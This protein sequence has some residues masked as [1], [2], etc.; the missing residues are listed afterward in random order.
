[1]DQQP[2]FNPQPFQHHQP[3]PAHQYQAPHQAHETIQ[4]PHPAGRLALDAATG[5]Q[6]VPVVK[7]LSP[8]GVEYVFLTLTL[9]VGAGSLIGVLLALVNGGT[10]FQD[11][12][13]PVAS[14]VVTVPLFA[15]LFLHLKKLEL[16]NPNLALDPSKRRSTQATQILSFLVSLFTFIGF[17]F[18]I[19]ASMSGQVGTSAGKAALDAL[20]VLVVS[21]GILWY[22]WRDEHKVTR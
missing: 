10:S 6:P 12:S 8:V 9:L 22:Y 11:L 20:C 18:S 13:F 7:V 3:Q 15:L 4:Q 19:F 16:Q 14:L 2:N 17:I 5:I 21:G 1:M